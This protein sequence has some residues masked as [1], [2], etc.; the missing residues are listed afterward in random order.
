MSHYALPAAGSALGGAAGTALTEGNPVG[1]IVGST[2]GNI[3]GKKLDEVVQGSGLR[4]RG[5]KRKE[6]VMEGSGWLSGLLDK[7]F[8]ARQ[9]IQ[10]AKKLPDLAKS[11]A[12]DIRG[13]GLKPK[14]FVKGSEEARQFMSKLRSMRKKK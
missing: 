8:T 1:G 9:A 12:A 11:A 2:L 10:G 3:A 14:R 4:K 5:R 13:A 6:D 7:P